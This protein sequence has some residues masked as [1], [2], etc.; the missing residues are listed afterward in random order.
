M[1][2]P[3]TSRACATQTIPV[4]LRAHRQWVIWRLEV[5]EGK[6]TKVPYQARRPREK[7]DVTVP[8]TWASYEEAA[9]AA[10]KADGCG[11]V[12]TA[13]DPFAGVDLDACVDDQGELLPGAAAIVSRLDSYTERSPSGH[14]VHVIVRAQLHGERHRTSKSSWGGVF[15]VYDC[16][17]FFTITGA[18][19]GTINARQEQLDL[20]VAEILPARP[21]GPAPAANR[22]VGVVG[23]DDEELL[24]RA[25]AAQN[26]NR[27]EA[28]WRGDTSAYDGDDSVADFALCRLLAFW[29]G[30]DPERLDALF[31]RL[32]EAELATSVE[33]GLTDGISRPKDGTVNIATN[34]TGVSVLAE[35]PP[36]TAKRLGGDIDWPAPLARP[37]FHGLAGD[38]VSVIGP[39]SEADPAAL[40]VQ[41]L[42]AF[43]NAAGRGAGFRAEADFHALNLFVVLVGQTAKGRKGTS[44]G[45][46]GRIFERADPTWRRERVRGGASSGEGLIWA[47]RDPTVGRVAVKEKGKVVGYEDQESDPGGS[48]TSGCST[49]SLSSPRS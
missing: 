8:T 17:R 30:D 20:I 28:L 21:S 22:V 31:R 34:R 3:P 15:E 45:Q 9:S 18:G 48:V 36:P 2:E 42:V 24:R 38:V 26:G 6:R 12:F 1:R 44:W 19:S 35:P 7:A 40:L 25:F 46:I 39:H 37:A 49:S 43:G 5:R 33:S 13:A 41:Y 11:F 10:E 47:V 32:D 4:D 27:I 16:K 14:G 29:T 23:A